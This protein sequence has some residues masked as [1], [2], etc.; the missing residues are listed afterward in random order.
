[1]RR[2]LASGRAETRCGMR[3][4]RG[5]FT[6]IELLV[7]IAII[8]I[9]A[10][11]LLP[12]LNRAKL[13][14][15]S[16]GCKSNLRQLLIG[17]NVYAQQEGAYPHDL[18]AG[19][20]LIGS[21]PGGFSDYLRAPLP[22]HNYELTY[23]GWSYLGP[24]QSVWVCP[25]YNRIQA[26]VG[27]AV[28]TRGPGG[29]GGAGF[30]YSYNAW[31]SVPDSQQQLGL[32][33]Y[34]PGNLKIRESQVLSPSNM[35]GIGDADLVIDQIRNNAWNQPF[36]TKYYQAVIPGLPPRDSAVRAMKQRHDGRWNIG[37]CDGHLE[38]L[39]PTRLFDV[40]NPE[41]MRRW[42]NDHQPHNDGLVLPP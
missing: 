21:Q 39:K 14:A 26:L 13:A 23:K 38:N 19:N 5:A 16:A 34:W 33:G 36:P 42:N 27:G 30:S 22:Q 15:D 9:L 6:L 25:A 28:D 1:M 17:L 35:V 10:A 7:V 31:G 37:F 40:Q 12:A 20:G 4:Q 11:M 18:Y 41:Q 32:S 29:V 2:K 3:D 24:R 8:A